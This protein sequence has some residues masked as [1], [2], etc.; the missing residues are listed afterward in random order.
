[1]NR[2][3]KLTIDQVAL[4]ANVSR[5]TVSRVLNNHPKVSD[6]MRTRVKRVIRKHNY[7]PSSVARSLAS[8]RTYEICVISPRRRDDSLSSGY[9]PLLFRGISEECIRHG[10]FSS[11]TM[12]SEETAEDVLDRVLHEHVFDGY[13]LIT[14]EVTPFVAQSLQEQDLP[15][16]L[17]GQ[18]PNHPHI[19]SIDVDNFAGAYT[20]TMHL[21][22]QGHRRVGAVLGCLHLEETTERMAGYRKALQDAGLPMEERLVMLGSYD[23]QHGYDVTQRWLERGICPPAIFCGSDTIA[24]GALLALYK[25]GASVPNEVAVVG[26]DDIPNARFTAPPLTTVHQPIADKGARAVSMLLERLAQPG[27]P[28][29]HLR[30]PAELV[31]RDSCGGGG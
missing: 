7:R 27:V 19:S 22:R 20:A 25:A 26:F 28:S 17:I 8:D 23:E 15:V 29:H 6:E 13:L 21:V 24:T 10:Y 11:L 12:I 2:K 4:L 5:S 31:V 3:D 14:Q 30:L 1:M 9:W 16:V 18:D